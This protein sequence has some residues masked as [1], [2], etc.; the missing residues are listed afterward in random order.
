MNA[1]QNMDYFKLSQQFGNLLEMIKSKKRISLLSYKLILHDLQNPDEAF[2][3][4]SDEIK[5]LSPDEIRQAI[6]E[7]QE[8][9]QANTLISVADN[10]KIK[11]YD[12]LKSTGYD[13]KSISEKLDVFRN[14]ESDFIKIVFTSP[15]P[16]LSVFVVNT[17][18]TDFINYYT[19][20]TQNNQKQSLAALDTIVRAK[21]SE[22]QKK[23]SA[24]INS[25]ISAASRDAGASSARQQA[26]FVN[27]Q[28]SEA[29]SQKAAVIRNISSLQGAIAEVNNKLSGSG[30]YVTPSTSKDNSEIINIDN[31]LAAA[32]KRWVNNNFRAEDKATID[33]LQRVKS[34]IIAR[35]RT[36]R[37][38]CNSYPAGPYQ[39]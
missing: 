34:R 22:L 10:G 5:K 17:L 21:Q 31:Q 4:Y 16:R 28:I 1:E 30:G 39:R 2:K 8:R 36:I 23:N 38:Q 7:Y 24:L 18:S 33:S 37:R 25:S 15:N 11:L 35:R 6:S 26:D 20:L 32:N 27:Q 29:Q 13:D 14:G 3:P 19:G 9:Y 12:I